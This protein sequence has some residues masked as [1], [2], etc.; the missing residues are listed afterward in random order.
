[1]IY[2]VMNFLRQRLEAALSE[3][4]TPAEPLMV[5]S[6]PWS[7]ND[8]NKGSSF[9]NAMSL[10]NV[11]EERIFKTQ[12]PAVVRKENGQY[13]RKEPD[14]KLNLY[15]LISAYHKN[16]EDGLKFLSRVVTFFQAN[17]VFQ[18]QPGGPARKEDLPEGIDKII[19]ELYT[20]GFEQQN[21][22]WASLSTGY[23]PSVIFKI[24]M[25]IIDSAP[26]DQRVNPV[27]EIKTTF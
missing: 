27:T 23:V 22:I 24:R 21:Q 4:R 11:E 7:N 1:M 19:A 26:A 14:L 8:S 6:N 25:I 15:V 5:L 9:L 20:A 10:I 17:N 3:G 16:Y 13:Y 2:D 18:N 12:V